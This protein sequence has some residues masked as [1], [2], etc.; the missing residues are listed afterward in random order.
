MFLF[1]CYC[2]LR[3]ILTFQ[4][5]HLLLKLDCD[6][7]NFRAVLPSM[8]T[9]QDSNFVELITRNLAEKL[10][11]AGGDFPACLVYLSNS[12]FIT[13]WCFFSLAE[14]IST[15]FRPS[16]KAYWGGLTSVFWIMT[17]SYFATDQKWDTE[18]PLSGACMTCA[19]LKMYT[20][21]LCYCTRCNVLLTSGHNFVLFRDN[22]SAYRLNRRNCYS[23]LSHWL[24]E[25]TF[26]SYSGAHL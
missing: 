2:F 20:A 4:S 24:S 12:Y 7:W 18:D 23:T 26:F 25:E 10:S 15:S 13:F 9:F 16:W 6:L 3:S 22:A 5:C 11:E 17:S 21:W 8:N 19:Y 1:L 14:W